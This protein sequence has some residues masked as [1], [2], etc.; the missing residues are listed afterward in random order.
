[1]LEE[2]K[3]T[4]GY[5]VAVRILGLTISVIYNKSQVMSSSLFYTF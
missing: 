5:I 1:M 4:P 2:D 3:S